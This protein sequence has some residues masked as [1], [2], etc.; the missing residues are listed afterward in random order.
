M[1]LHYYGGLVNM[2][3][4]PVQYPDA[5]KTYLAVIDS[6]PTEQSGT[7]SLNRSKIISAEKGWRMV[8]AKK[9]KPAISH[10]ELI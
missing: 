4:R 7:I 6:E 3:G 5:G 10:W 2:I 8:A 1:A 9:G